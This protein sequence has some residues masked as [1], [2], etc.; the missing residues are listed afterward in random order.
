M[1][2]QSLSTSTGDILHAAH[3]LRAGELVAFPTETVY[4]LGAMVFNESAVRAIFTAKGRPSDNPLIVHCADRTDVERVAINI[5]PLFDAL[6]ERF[7]PGPL[8]M[9][10]ERHIAVPD[11]VTAGLNT[12]AVRFPAHPVA[13]TL[14]RTAGEPLVAPSANRSGRPSPTQAQHV[15]NDLA[16][17]IAAVIDGGSCEVGIESTVLNILTNPPVILRPGSITKEMLE[18]VVGYEV[19]HGSYAIKTSN[20]GI[21]EVSFPTLAPGMKYRHYAPEARIILVD[22]MAEAL[23]TARGIE[24]QRGNLVWILS[25]SVKKPEHGIFLLSEQTLYAMFRNADAQNVGTLILV[26]DPHVRN[27]EGLMNRIQ[28][29]ASRK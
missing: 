28:K 6:F 24:E 12:V 14:I 20:D 16:G 10:L 26:C 13:E 17:R 21:S 15:M 7:C 29:A 5:P 23:Q 8:T 27:N 19:V 3:L 9:L 11:A 4:G 22:S 18:D 25:N 1:Q 2:T